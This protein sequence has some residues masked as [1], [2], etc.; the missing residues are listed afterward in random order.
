MDLEPLDDANGK[1]ERAL[2]EL[3]QLA[4]TNIREDAFLNAFVRTAASAADA[5]AIWIWLINSDGRLRPLACENGESVDVGITID[6]RA[7]TQL[8]DHVLKSNQHAAR[9]IP[10]ADRLG[11][12]SRQLLTAPL[13]TGDRIAGVIEAAYGVP[14]SD[15]HLGAA[16]SFLA[17]AG[18]CFTRYLSWREESNDPDQQLLFW[19]RFEAALRRIYATLDPI[20]VAVRA[21]NEGRTLI[22]C[23]RVTIALGLPRRPFVAATTGV[24][25]VNQRSALVRS[26]IR[27]AAAVAATGESLTFVGQRSDFPP[28]VEAL[29]SDFVVCSGAHSVHVV[30]LLNVED[31]SGTADAKRPTRKPRVAG[32]MLTEQMNDTALTPL[33]SSR[34][35][36]FAA[37]V[38]RA[39]VNAEE[40]RRVFLLPLRRRLGKI[41]GGFLE[42][43]PLRWAVCGLALAASSGLLCL[44]DAP[45]RVEAKGRLMPAEQRH[46]Y[47]PL[48]GQVVQLFVSGGD[49]VRVGDPLAELRNDR[50]ATELLVARNEF[51]EK[52]QVQET[53]RAQIESTDHRAGSADEIRLRGQLLRLEI[54]LRGANKRIASLELQASSLLVRSPIEGTVVSF[55]VEDALMNRPVER[56]TLLLDVMNISGGWQLELEIPEKHV[57]AVTAIRGHADTSSL[58][59]Q[60]ILETAPETS[61]EAVLQQVGTTADVSERFGL[62]VH[63][64][65]AIPQNAM[66]TPRVGAEVDAKID[67]GRRRLSA[68]LFGDFVEFLRRKIW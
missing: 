61:H 31:R 60:F 25:R 35:D 23:D 43:R 13:Q 52:H 38:A 3:E 4:S 68:V 53:L 19:N 26:M 64:V 44:V 54:E 63:A 14:Q 2:L 39:L 10:I 65:A 12:G 20:E 7:R 9:I 27:L 66:T 48:E 30:P 37:H 6:N 45:Y 17:D 5:S 18:H 34:A 59:V 50:L 15:D 8:R 42:Y 40:H 47:A 21:V 29:I 56:G 32:V 57:G 58:P 28:Q 24:S 11:S 46:V 51:Q 55:Q 22:G 49:H 33:Q 62:A 16:A 41:A 67:C 36:L 1:R